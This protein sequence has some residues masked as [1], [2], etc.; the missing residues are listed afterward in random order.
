MYIITLPNGVVLAKSSSVSTD[1]NGFTRDDDSSL[2][3]GFEV[4]VIELDDDKVPETIDGYQYTYTE[5]EGFIEDPN[6]TPVA[7]GTSEPIEV[8]LQNALAK[9]ADLEE[10]VCE[11]SELIESEEVTE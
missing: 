2:T 9:I 8:Q 3:Y 10:A 4:N 5:E 11:L 6:Y 7:S 1:V